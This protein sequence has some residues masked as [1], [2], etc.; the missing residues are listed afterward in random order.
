MQEGGAE[1]VHLII[2][3]W[4][5]TSKLARYTVHIELATKQKK[6][7]YKYMFLDFGQSYINIELNKIKYNK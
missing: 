6:P 7:E 5:P 1:L 3:C 4:I 2:F